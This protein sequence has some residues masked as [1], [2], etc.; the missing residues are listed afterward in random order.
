[1]LRHRDSAHHGSRA[2]RRSRAPTAPPRNQRPPARPSGTVSAA[3]ATAKVNAAIYTRSRSPAR[4][5]HPQS[6]AYIQRKITE[7]KTKREAHALPESDTSPAT[8]TT[9]FAKTPLTT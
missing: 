6:R 2:R 5:H 4:V 7:G 3:E 1:M 8:S 9:N